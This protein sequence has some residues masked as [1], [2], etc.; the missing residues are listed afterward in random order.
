MDIKIDK[1]TPCLENAV[2]GEILPTYFELVE[3][4]DLKKSGNWKFNWNDSSLKDCLIYK[5]LV[6]DS[7]EIQG[8]VALE[9]FIKDKAIYVKIAESAPHNI[10][11]NKKYNGVGGHLFAIAAQ[12]S[13]ELGYDGFLFMDAKNLDLV[14]HYQLALGAVFLGMPHPYRMFI[15]EVA[16]KKLLTTY[17]LKEE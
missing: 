3:N 6:N 12:Q 11:K 14:K 4:S 9:K 16:A 13:M 17:S 8:L 2:T 15:D 10:G 7:S 5:L 1:F